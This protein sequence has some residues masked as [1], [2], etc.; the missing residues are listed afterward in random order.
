VN[1]DNVY[2]QHILDAIE[3]IATYSAVGRD[4]F[5]AEPHWHDA[6][7]RQLEIIGEATKRLS[8][9]LRE[10]HPAVPWRRIAG[11]RDVLIHDYMGVDLDTVWTITRGALPQLRHSIEA[12]LIE[13]DA[14]QA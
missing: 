1:R 11:L 8:P 9:A 3:R 5:M 4:R 12:I 6:V 2:F 14:P 10:Q 7:I 13:P